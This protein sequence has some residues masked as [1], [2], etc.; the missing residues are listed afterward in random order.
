MVGKATSATFEAQE[1][2][3]FG[4]DDSTVQYP[5]YVYVRLYGKRIKA[6]IDSG[7]S[8]SLI[9]FQVVRSIPQLHNAVIWPSRHRHMRSVDGS[10]I[11]LQ[12]DFCRYEFR[13]ISFWE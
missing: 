7:A 13:G 5:T 1:E 12:G 8:R 4:M 2:E 11:T 6:L 9:N 10:K 3:N